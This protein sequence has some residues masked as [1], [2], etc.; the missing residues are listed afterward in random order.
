[1]RGMMTVCVATGLALS[2]CG[3]GKAE[4]G[5]GE[6]AAAST[7]GIDPC[8]LLTGEEVTAITTDK[9]ID[10]ER[11][12]GKTCIYRSNPDDGPQV[13]ILETGGAKQMEVVHKTAKVL[14]GMGAAVA[15]KGGAGGDV[16]NMLKEDKSAPP[17]LG[18]EAVWGMNSTLSVRKGDAFVEV[19]P[20]LM[21]DPANHAGYPL[22]SKEDK[23]AIAQAIATKV[24]AKLGG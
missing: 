4:V 6:T 7:E 17:P 2:G 12:D 18:D 10:L 21:H 13:T 16:A 15:D 3:G 5:D 24:L 19:T 11:Q 23:R 9:V 22:V 20:P 14:G 1:M 8:S